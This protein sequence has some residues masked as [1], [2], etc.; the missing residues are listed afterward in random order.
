[1]GFESIMILYRFLYNT[2]THAYCIYVCLC[3]QRKIYCI[4]LQWARRQ[5]VHSLCNT[6]CHRSFNKIKRHTNYTQKHS[7][8]VQTCCG[9]RTVGGQPCGFECNRGNLRNHQKMDITASSWEFR[10]RT[11][12]EISLD[13]KRWYC[14]IRSSSLP[15]ENHREHIKRTKRCCLSLLP[16]HA[17]WSSEECFRAVCT[18]FFVIV[19]F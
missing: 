16:V 1:M 14:E 8:V 9:W 13:A 4:H 2:H 11:T 7:R 19:R 3:R 5:T 18:T 10:Q 6:V 12:G 17:D 15:E